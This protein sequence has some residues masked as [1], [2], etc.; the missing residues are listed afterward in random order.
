MS[1]KKAAILAGMLAATMAEEERKSYFKYT[2][3]YAGLEELTYVG[4]GQNGYSKSP[5]SK[6]QKKA[7]AASKRAKKSRKRNK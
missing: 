7:R 2:N 1:N 6:K 4:T 5:L 3:P